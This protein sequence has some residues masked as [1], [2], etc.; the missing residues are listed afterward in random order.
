MEKKKSVDF[1]GEAVVKYEKLIIC[2]VL[3][4][5]FPLIQL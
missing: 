4:Y 1:L 3:L 2:F 5:V